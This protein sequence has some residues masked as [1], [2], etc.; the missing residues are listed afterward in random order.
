MKIINKDIKTF[1]PV[2]PSLRQRIVIRSTGL[3][4]GN[5]EKYLSKGTCSTGGRNNLGRITVYHRGGAHKRKYRIID[6]KRDVGAYSSATVLRIEYD[7]NRSAN[8]ALCESTNKTKFYILAPAG[9]TI[10]QTIYGKLSPISDLTVGQT[11]V[12]ADLPIGSVVHNLGSRFGRAAGTS[13]TIL[14]HNPESTI[15]R[16]PSKE[17]KEF[18]NSLYATIGSVSNPS[19]INRVLGKAGASAWI[20]RLPRVKGV[21]MNPI[22]HPHGGKT[23]VSGGK[24]SP[25]RNRWGK[26]AKWQ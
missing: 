1:K 15:I 16:L 6:F 12:L 8:I 18:P 9:L 17:I 26:L 10:N 14:K 25:A 4:K 11:R 7:P 21:K 5:S 24:G 20:G 13:A 23:P 3:Y 19:H 2:T 22:D